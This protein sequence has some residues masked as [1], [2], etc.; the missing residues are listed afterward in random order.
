MEN[1]EN[2]V[3]SSQEELEKYDYLI[4]L[5]HKD[6]IMRSIFS[7]LRLPRVTLHKKCC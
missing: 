6:K 2:E 4:D 5:L 3:I 7:S 1:M